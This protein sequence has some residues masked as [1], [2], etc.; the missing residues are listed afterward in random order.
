MVVHATGESLSEPHGAGTHAVV[1][2]ADQLALQ[3]LIG[4]LTAANVP[5]KAICD[6][7]AGVGDGV[8]ALGIAPGA[9]EVR[10][11]YVSSLPLLR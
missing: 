6:P 2:A 8:L 7:D 5:F 9:K 3:M 10:S 11:R 4:R 1:L